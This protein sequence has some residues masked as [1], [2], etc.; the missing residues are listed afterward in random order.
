[1]DWGTWRVH[2]LNGAWLTSEPA[3][4]IAVINPATEE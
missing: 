4:T 3:D 1:M 2:Y